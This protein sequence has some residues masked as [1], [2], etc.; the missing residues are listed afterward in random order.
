MRGVRRTEMME[1]SMCFVLVVGHAGCSESICGHD[2]VSVSVS[3]LVLVLVLVFVWLRLSLCVSISVCLSL[4]S[5][6]VDDQ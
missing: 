5:V 6:L 1:I 2:S 3:V 4:G